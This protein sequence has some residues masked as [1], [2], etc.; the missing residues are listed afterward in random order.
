VSAA[1]GW[2]HLLPGMIIAGAG[3]GLVTVPLAS[4]AVGVV[5]VARA[6][7]ASGI[8]STFRQVGLA[9]GIAVLGSVFTARLAAAPGPLAGLAARTA[10]AAALNDI[11]LIGSA[12]ALVA[13][14]SSFA[15]IR[16]RD[17]VASPPGGNQ[18]SDLARAQED[19]R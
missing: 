2:T 4:T 3:T 5:D 12:T 16:R 13:A 1:D 19:P 11:L 15:F 7:M 18:S 9:T 6:G 8:N 17:F 14:A 10:Y